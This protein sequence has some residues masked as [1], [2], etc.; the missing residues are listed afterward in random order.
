MNMPISV[1]I[2]DER[3]GIEQS[4]RGVFDH[5]R[6]VDEQFSVFKE[7]S[8]I[9]AINAGKCDA[10]SCSPEMQE[11]LHLSEK[12]KQETGGYFDIRRPDGFL[13]PSGVVKGWA[14]HRAARILRNAGFENFF[15]EAGGDIQVSGRNSEG[16][17]WKIGIRDPLHEPFTD[18]I[19]VVYL[20]GWRG[21]ATSGTYIRGQHI[22]DPHT[23]AHELADVVSLTVIGENICDADRYA[24]AAFAMG[25]GGID[26]IEKL[27]GYEGYA[28]DS[29][30]MAL[31]TSGFAA[32]TT[33]KD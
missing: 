22:Y 8:E 3:E 17:P 25:R 10:G 23:P 16:K 5:F 32:Y 2:V 28:V 31:A 4:I 14:I 9:S 20:E 33:P 6:Q 26:F 19:K 29:S 21:I 30:G 24:T 18:L 13:N 27:P 7:T 12:T 15:V 11:I 1:E